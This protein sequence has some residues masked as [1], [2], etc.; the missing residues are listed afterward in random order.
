MNIYSLRDLKLQNL[1]E[2]SPKAYARFLRS[3]EL[4][5]YLDNVSRAANQELDSLVDAG[6]SDHEAWEVVRADFLMPLD[7]ESD[8][9]G[10]NDAML[11]ALNETI[12]LLNSVGEELAEVP[13]RSDREPEI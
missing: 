13:P 4:E 9:E 5:K 10:P 12:D 1:Q 7:D 6:Y 8:D 11:S 3:G 2:F